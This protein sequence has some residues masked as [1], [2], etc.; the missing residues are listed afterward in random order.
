MENGGQRICGKERV[1]KV[2]IEMEKR[3][4]IRRND[5][6]KRTVRRKTRAPQRRGACSV[7]R[8][9]RVRRGRE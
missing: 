6:G 5:A 2:R 9:G 7:P 1:E 4:W 8:H 3:E